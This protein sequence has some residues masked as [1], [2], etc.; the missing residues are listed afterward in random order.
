MIGNEKV[1]IIVPVYNTKMQLNRCIESL[2]QQTYEN[3]EIILIDDCSSD[4]SREI[5]EKFSAISK[6]K[7]IYNQQNL[8][9]VETRAKGIEIA[10]GEWISFVDSDDYV[11]KNF[12]SYM[13]GQIDDS[14][15]I[16]QC[17][18]IRF[19]KEVSV[20]V[21]TEI[22]GKEV[23]DDQLERFLDMNFS[24]FLWD[25]LYRKS[26]FADIDM[27]KNIIYGEDQLLNYFLLKKCRKVVEI[28]NKL[29]YYCD[30]ED[31]ITRT[32]F[33]ERKYYS[34]V[35]VVKNIFNDSVCNY[36]IKAKKFL[37]T[38]CFY[39]YVY[40][41][42]SNERNSLS[43]QIKDV[44]NIIKNNYIK[45]DF[46]GHTMNVLLFLIRY[47]DLL[48]KIATELWIRIKKLRK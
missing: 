28:K 44:K 48:A 1:S 20:E 7:A 33:N 30:R 23:Y 24:V 11:D 21:N 22:L 39:A 42:V 8:G 38:K 18:S 27:P 19:D 41:Q 5:I 13:I 37:L 26:L 10:T 15:D 36:P 34:Y 9:V 2:I 17:N 47:N 25:K 14:V 12:I 32:A 35:G 16:V 31:S 4:G 43:E 46:G 40:M 29:Y 3:I 45:M 6:I